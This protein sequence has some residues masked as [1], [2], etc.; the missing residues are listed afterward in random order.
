MHH[1]NNVGWNTWDNK[2]QANLNKSNNSL[3]EHRGKYVTISRLKNYTKL[4]Q[5]VTHDLEKYEVV[6]RR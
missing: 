5:I 2:S 1:K 3:I 6:I 4:R